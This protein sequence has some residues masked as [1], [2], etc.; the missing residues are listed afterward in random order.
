MSTLDR[1]PF[2]R[3]AVIGTI[4]S[5]ATC[6]FRIVLLE[7][8]WQ[9]DSAPFELNPHV[10]A[11]VMTAFAVLALVGLYFD[12]K[13]HGSVLPLVVGIIGVSI[14]VGTLYVHYRADVEF[15]GYIMLIVA[16]FLNQTIQ[17]KRLNRTVQALNVELTERAREAH[18]ATG[19][20]SRFLANLSHELRTPL[21]AIIGISRDV[22]S[23]ARIVAA[24]RHL[25]AL[26]DDILDLSKIEA[27]R[28]ELDSQ[29]VDVEGLLR[30]IELTVRPLAERNGNALEVSGD[31][32]VGAVMGDQLRI[33]Q[34]ILNLA[35]NACKFTQNGRVAIEAVR[36]RDDGSEWVRFIVRDTGVGISADDLA[37]LFEEFS[38]ARNRGNASGGTGLGLAI[39]QRLCNLMGGNIVVESTPGSG[40]TFTVRLPGA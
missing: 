2:G 12:R 3:L 32:A 20:K 38:Q 30:D 27:N 8:V 16:V 13:D 14:I 7:L 15:T 28:M 36:D 40:S 22:D 34:A 39:S 5:V 25:L 29:P 10:Q 35:S 4:G 26:V 18:E 21:N 17:L 23:H 9:G 11:A 31:D 19:A 37:H 1:I 24:G 33:R 6:Y